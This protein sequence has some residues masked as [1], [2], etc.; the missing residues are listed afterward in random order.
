MRDR[1]EMPFVEVVRMLRYF[2]DLGTEAFTLS[3]GG[4]PTLHPEIERII[5]CA[6]KMGFDLGIVTNGLRWAEHINSPKRMNTALTWA[7]M[8]VVNTSGDYDI[9]LIRRFAFNLSQVD[10]GVSFVVS[11]DVCVEQA[12]KICELVE[13][14]DNI[15]HIKF[16]QDS[17][18]L[19]RKHMAKIEHCKDIT[20]KAYFLFRDIRERGS[21]KCRVALLKPLIDAAGNV[22]PCC[23]VQHAIDDHH[24]V[25]EKF[26]MCHWSEFASAISFDGSGCEKCYYGVYNKFLDELFTRSKHDK[27]L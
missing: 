4:E 23:D 10:V 1:T 18:C 19:D 16:T 7:R 9:G 5:W 11:E 25:P 27:F 8:S 6:Y 22:Y 24:E 12:E 3:G 21:K 17:Y 13:N 26:K 20:D 15:T 2:R 14:T